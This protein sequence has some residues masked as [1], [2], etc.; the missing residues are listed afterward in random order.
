MI[1]S[2][3]LMFFSSDSS[4]CYF[5]RTKTPADFLCAQSHIGFNRSDPYIKE[6]DVIFIQ[7][8]AADG[9]TDWI[10]DMQSQGKKIVYDI[11]DNLWELSVTNPASKFYTSSRLKEIKNIIRLCDAVVVSTFPLGRYFKNN[12]FNNNIHVIH[13]MI[14]I[15]EDFAFRDVDYNKDIVRI[16]YSGSPTHSQDFS[17]MLHK[18]LKDIKKKYKDKVKLVCMG[19]NPLTGIDIEYHDYVKV[20]EYLNKL[21][22]LNLDIS[23]CPLS[24]TTFNASKSNL[25]F[26]ENSICKF[27]SVVSDTVS[28]NTTTEHMKT[29]IIISNEKNWYK[30]FEQLIEDTSL[31]EKLSNSAF[32][33]VKNNYTLNYNG[34]LIKDKYNQLLRSI[35]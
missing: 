7:R 14:N 32:E 30:S 34:Q 35:F 10:K 25:K 18:A 29:G 4:G 26:L 33:Y 22:S 24:N 9:I 1:N 13:N 21:N 19:Y 6:A 12:N 11:D 31:R 27:A 15:P 20:T 17:Y 8:V 2:K 3:K 16:G 23:L 5:Y 28:Y